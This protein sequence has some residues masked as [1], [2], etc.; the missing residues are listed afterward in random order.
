MGE[1][2]RRERGHRCPERGT[3][4][5]VGYD[6]PSDS[7]LLQC[8]SCGWTDRVAGEVLAEGIDRMMGLGS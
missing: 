5:R 3:A 7:A 8:A 4:A 2:V 1:L 6:H